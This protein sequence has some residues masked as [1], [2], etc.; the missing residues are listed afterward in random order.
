M[1][2][3]RVAGRCDGRPVRPISAALTWC[4]MFGSVVDSWRELAAC[5][6]LRFAVEAA[7]ADPG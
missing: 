6:A 2:R 5:E 4:Q 7:R 1:D 3:R